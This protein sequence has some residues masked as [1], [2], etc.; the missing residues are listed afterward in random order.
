MLAWRAYLFVATEAKEG[1]RL[2]TVAVVLLGR[3]EERK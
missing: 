2:R 3:K 1:A